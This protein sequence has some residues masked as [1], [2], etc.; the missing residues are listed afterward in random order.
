MRERT[1]GVALGLGHI[2][3]VQPVLPLVRLR[4]IIAKYR[5]EWKNDSCI[6]ALIVRLD[7]FSEASSS[8]NRFSGR[9]SV[10]IKLHITAQSGPVTLVI[11]CHSH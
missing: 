4:Y 9:R 10:C 11:L 1:R 5:Y 2:S 7:Y 8:D 6:F 3:L